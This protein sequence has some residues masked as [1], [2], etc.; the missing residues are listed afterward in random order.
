MRCS[1][2]SRSLKEVNNDSKLETLYS[3]MMEWLLF[4]D[5]RLISTMFT[6]SVSRVY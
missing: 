6:L 4:K 2:E 1:K 5:P 3:S